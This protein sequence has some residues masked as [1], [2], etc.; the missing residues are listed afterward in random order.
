MREDKH[1]GFAAGADAESTHIMSERQRNGCRA[2]ARAERWQEAASMEKRKRR[3]D[4]VYMK[5]AI[6]ATAFLGIVEAADW[7]LRIFL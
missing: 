4:E 6:A 7:L 1:S 3:E 5:M 2:A